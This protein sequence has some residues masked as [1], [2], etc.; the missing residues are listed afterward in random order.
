MSEQREHEQWQRTQAREQEKTQAQQMAQRRA[1]NATPIID[2]QD[3]GAE[4][5]DRL[6]KIG[7][8][9]ER[10]D[11]IEDLLAPFLS[12]TQML[13]DHDS[14]EY[15]DDISFELLNA[16]LADRLIKSRERGR[17]LTGPFLDVARDVEHENGVVESRP[18]GPTE[19][20]AIREALQTVRTDRQSLGRGDFL[21]SI[22]EM[23]VSSEVRRGDEAQSENSGGILSAINP[24]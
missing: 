24:F 7:I 3:G 12:Q 17:L 9:S 4:I 1:Q 21:K 19:K 13:A 23:H 18:L 22:T 14:E 8:E 5:F 2:M 16:N 15:Y 10:Y 6:T 20:E 11:G